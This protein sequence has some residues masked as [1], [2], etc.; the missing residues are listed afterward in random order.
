MSCGT[1]SRRGFLRG[2]AFGL[3]AAA[4]APL[5]GRVAGTAAAAFQA[6][7]ISKHNIIVIMTDD[8][9][10]SSMPVMRKLMAR[11]HGSWVTF[12]N[13]VCNDPICAPSRATFFSGQHS[14]KHGV[15]KNG[16]D[17]R[18]DETRTVPVWLK[19]AGYRTALYGKYQNG[20]AKKK[21]ADAAGVGHLRAVRRVSG[22]VSG[23]GHRLHSP[24]GRA[25]FPLRHT[26]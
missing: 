3:T 21:A 12:N 24:H 26:G 20:W 18:L 1:V 15:I 2:A 4:T 8:Q 25:V 6:P 13:A 10:A 17:N 16:W 23:T 9:A 11:P 14:H 19:G 22:R 5:A 7:S